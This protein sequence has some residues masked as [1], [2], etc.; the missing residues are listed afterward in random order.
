M[1]CWGE[2][3]KSEAASRVGGGRGSRG[4]GRSR[5]FLSKLRRGG[6]VAQ[7]GGGE[8]GGRSSF[9]GSVGN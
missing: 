3:P 8:V 6:L 1:V 5:G 9:A 7:L 2:R 4:G